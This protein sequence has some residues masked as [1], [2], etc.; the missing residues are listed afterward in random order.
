MR[1][2][3]LRQVCRDYISKHIAGTS[4]SDKME[5]DIIIETDV[6]CGLSDN[7]KLT[8][9]HIYQER[10]TGEIVIQFLGDNDEYDLDG[11]E[12][13]VYEQIAQYFYDYYEML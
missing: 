10:G 5:V 4:E 9:T 3:V 7:E 2:E 8:I 11:Y 13:S 6:D 1:D 12:T